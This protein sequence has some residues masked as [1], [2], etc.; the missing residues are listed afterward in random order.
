MREKGNKFY[1]KGKY[2]KCLEYY[3]RAMSLFRWLEYKEK[4]P[5]TTE[6]SLPAPEI[7]SRSELSDEE[8]MGSKV[9]LNLSD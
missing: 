2:S 5:I 4:K 8:S 6:L 7:T 1:N 3:E 9:Y